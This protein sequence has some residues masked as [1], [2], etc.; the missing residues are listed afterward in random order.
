[1]LRQ[2]S[3][4]GNKAPCLPAILMA[5]RTCWSNAHGIA[6]CSKSRATLDAPGSPHQATTCSV[7]PRQPP[8]QQSTKWQ[9]NNTP[10]FLAILMAIA[11]QWYNTAHIVQWR[12]S[13]ASLEATGRR[14]PT[15][16]CSDNINWPYLNLFRRQHIENG[17]KA[18]G[19]LL[20]TIG[21]QHIKLK[22][23]I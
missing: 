15:S 17:R 22:G 1:M 5:M 6:Q 3:S 13:R 21:V 11:M 16:T 8:G 18:K 12:R 4:M 9:S 14:H 19:W 2:K 10:I 7:L 20:I 23:S